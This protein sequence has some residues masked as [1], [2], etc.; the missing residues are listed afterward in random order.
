MYA[1]HR[2]LHSALAPFMVQGASSEVSR[3][4][5]DQPLSEEHAGGYE[6]SVATSRSSPERTGIGKLTIFFSL[7]VLNC[8][9]M[10]VNVTVLCWI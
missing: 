7:L 4:K 1:K 5:Y 6:G 8:I 9:F 2:G 3:S 10:M